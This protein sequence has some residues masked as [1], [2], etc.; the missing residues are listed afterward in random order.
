MSISNVL[1]MMWQ[2]Y[3][4]ELMFLVYLSYEKCLADFQQEGTFGMG[5][6]LYNVYKVLFQGHSPRKTVILQSLKL[7]KKSNFFYHCHF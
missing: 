5:Y 4:N 1:R 6:R 3:V 7:Q 2:V